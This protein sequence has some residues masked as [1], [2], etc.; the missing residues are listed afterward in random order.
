MVIWQNNKLVVI[1]LLGL[2]AA[3]FVV[4]IRPMIGIKAAYNEHFGCSPVK[5]E[6]NVFVTFFVTTTAVDFVI[7]LLTVYKTYN[8]YKSVYHSGLIKLIFRDGLVYFAVV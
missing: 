7:L 8:E 4:S 6:I 1:G 5:V 3:Q 2:L